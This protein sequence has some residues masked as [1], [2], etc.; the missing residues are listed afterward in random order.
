[1]TF[2]YIFLM[3][4]WLIFGVIDWTARIPTFPQSTLMH[5]LMRCPGSCIK[6]LGIGTG[7]GYARGRNGDSSS[8]IISCGASVCND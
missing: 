8:S 4:N 5:C 2:C 3:L 6:E 1:M 7:G